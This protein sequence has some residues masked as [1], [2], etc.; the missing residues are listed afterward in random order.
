MRFKILVMLF[1]I[2]SIK[3]LAQRYLDSIARIEG[4]SESLTFDGFLNEELWKKAKRFSFIEWRPEWGQKDS[5]TTLFVTFDTDYLYVG[6]DARDPQ[7]EKIVSRNLVRDGWYGDDYFAFQI[8]PNRTQKNAFI[9]SIYPSGSRYDDAIYNDNVPLG[10]PAVGA[11]YDMIWD[12]KSQITPQGWQAEY[13]IPLANLRFEVRNGVVLGGISAQR[14]I[15]YDNK[16]LVYP[17]IP[18]NIPGANGKPSLKKPVEFV[19]LQ[20]KKELQ[21]TPYIL[22]G[23]NNSY[24]LNDVST[25]YEK[26]K[27]TELDGGLDVRIGLTPSLTLDLTAN[28]DF[29][30]VEVDDQLINLDRSTIFFPERRKFFLEQSGLF[31][32]NTGILSQL[33]YSRTIGI[34]NGQLTPI[35]GGVKLTG[36]LGDWDVGLINLQTEGI[37]LEGNSLPSEN[38]GVLRLRRQLFNA[39]S[40]LGFMATN[41]LHKDYFNTAL[42]ID[43][44][45]DLG[46]ENFFLG[47]IATTFEGANYGEATYSV[48]EQSRVALQF[49][50][51][52]DDGWFYKTN[53]E[54]SGEAFNPGMGFL[55]RERH[56]NL[57]LQLDHGKFKK[58]KEEGRFQYRKWFTDSDLYF[59]TDFSDVLSWYNRTQWS[60]RFFSADQLSFFGQL[61]YEFLQRPL[62]FSPTISIPEGYYFF[63][64]FGASFSSG[65]QRAIKIPLSVQYGEFFDGTNFELRLSPEWSINEHFTFEGSWR[66]NYLNFRDRNVEE[67]IGIPQLR[68]N[69][70]ANLKLSGSAT[71]QYNSI[72][73]QWVTSARLRYNFKDGHNLYLVYNQDYNE[74]RHRLV[75][76]LPYYNN[77]V[78]A[79]KYL[80][81]FI[82]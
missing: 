37:L 15:N 1:L 44:V 7:P 65:F 25:A 42:G 21:I 50:K 38:F 28:T 63:K 27:G 56:H 76:N 81:T 66:I 78:F 47:S 2:L 5:L 52:K 73:D 6:L 51:R 23:V 79:L 34:N 30:Q 4:T 11:A 33:F 32:F 49:N 77:Q 16:L 58:T 19:G 75:P 35:I 64:F 45:V 18:Q 40:F 20:P 9:F 61:Q 13:R 57:Y 60:G 71:A 29:S 48:F 22:G 36:E 31:D 8:D 69:W 43:G 80:Y 26:S 72:T 53:Y 54:Y 82:K 3:G 14:T 62:P 59:T 17:E 12:G 68:M 39:R 10:R 55:L 41:R 24:R 74:D 67:W 46:N 70:A